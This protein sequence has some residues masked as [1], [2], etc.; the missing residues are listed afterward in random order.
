M[1]DE[2]GRRIIS[3]PE[4]FNSS[5]HRPLSVPGGSTYR[6]GPGLSLSS[7]REDNVLSSYNSRDALIS[8]RLLHGYN[9]LVPAQ[10]M[11]LCTLLGL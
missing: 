7:S 1:K 2:R 9:C 5:H 6:T 3:I 11:S 4:M 8:T 10:L